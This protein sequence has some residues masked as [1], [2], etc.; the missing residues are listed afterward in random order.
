[1]IRLR[2]VRYA[3]PVSGGAWALN[4]IDLSIREGEYVYVCG[5][6]GSGKSTLAY[7]LNGLIPHFFGGTLEGSVTVQGM[8][9]RTTPV[10]DL[11]PHVGLVHQN[12]DAHLFNADVESEI[13][14]GLESLGLPASEIFARI[15]Q[16]SAALHVEHLLRRSPMAL[17]AGEKRLVA[18]ASVLCLDPSIVVLD[19]PYA[20]LDWEGAK[21][22]RQALVRV[23]RSGKTVL[24][25]EHRA[26]GFLRDATRCLVLDQ[27]RVAF[28]GPSKHA[29]APMAAHWLIPGYTQRRRKGHRDGNP[30]LAVRDLSFR[31]GG[32]W[33]LKKVSFQVGEGESVAIVGK[34]GAGKTTLIKQLNGLL[35]PTQGEV[36][37]MGRPVRGRDPSELAS[38][39]GLSFQNANDQF[40]KFRV[41]DEL[42]VGL[43]AHPRVGEEEIQRLCDLFGLH[44]LLDRSPFRLSEGEK[45]RVALASVLAGGARILVL[46]EP[47][48]GQDGRTREA[49]AGLLGTLEE[50]GYTILIVTHDLEFAQA[51]AGRW[52]VLDQGE[53]LG[54]GAPESLL[55]KGPLANVGVRDGKGDEEL[56]IAGRL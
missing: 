23:H 31:M 10:S 41:R 50:R 27:G 43:R 52:I 13:A 29:H 21:M 49:L 20:H 40:F 46:D 39:I 16:A 47:T 5:A 37:V 48:V 34:N 14:F 22:I 18:V 32:R 1:M 2:G 45:K 44:G 6:S 36:M 25:V 53:V 56:S 42:L 8:D 26:D 35:R 4:G 12:A 54:E 7:L 15:R 9:I 11:F 17:S 30:V 51:A 55:G 19:E 38:S 24:V 33:L 3:Y 28:D